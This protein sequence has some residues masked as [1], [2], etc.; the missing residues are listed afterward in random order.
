MKSCYGNN[1]LL[2]SCLDKLLQYWTY[3][4]TIITITTALANFIARICN[5]YFVADCLGAFVEQDATFQQIHDKTFARFPLV[6]PIN[7]EQRQETTDPQTKPTNL[8][9]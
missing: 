3:N 2:I 6:H 9:L 1:R 7:V 8:K 4:G 5:Y